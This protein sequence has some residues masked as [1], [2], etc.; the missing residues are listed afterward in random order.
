MCRGVGNTFSWRK[1]LLSPKILGRGK[2]WLSRLGSSRHRPPAFT[3]R[4]LQVGKDKAAFVPSCS[5][6]CRRGGNVTEPSAPALHNHL[7][8]RPRRNLQEKTKYNKTK[9]AV[10]VEQWEMCQGASGAG[11]S[12]QGFAPSQ[13]PAGVNFYL[14]NRDNLI[15]C[16]NKESRVDGSPATLSPIAQMLPPIPAEIQTWLINPPLSLPPHR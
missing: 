6:C 11:V 4:F 1:L 7:L 9:W 3:K 14:T 10:S 12:T 13:V 15:S 8:A 5:S 16:R 2:A